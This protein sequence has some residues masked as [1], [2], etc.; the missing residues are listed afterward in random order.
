MNAAGLDLCAALPTPDGPM[1]A[2]KVLWKVALPESDIAVIRVQAPAN[3]CLATRFAV[4]V[5]G[6][7]VQTTAPPEAMLLTDSSGRTKIQ[8]RVV[9]GYFSHGDDVTMFASFALPKG[10]SGAPMIVSEQDLQFVAGVF[11]GQSRG[12]EIEDEILEVA[13]VSPTESRRY[14]ERIS[15]VEYFARGDLLAR[16]KNFIAPEFDGLT[17]EAL[18]EKE[19][20]S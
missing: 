3:S 9:K 2:Q 11:V 10:M 12:E 13:D 20:S 1:R 14:T 16:Y 6:Q 17:L 5:M 15:R 8:M 18:I 7:D 4:P 19:V